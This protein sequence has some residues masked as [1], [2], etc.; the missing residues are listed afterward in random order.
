MRIVVPW[1][2]GA[3]T[4]VGTRALAQVMTGALGQPVVVENRAGANGALGAEAV[5]RAAPDGHT[6]LVGST[7]TQSINAQVF[8]RLAYDPVADFTPITQFARLPGALVVGPGLRQVADLAGFLAAVRAVPGRVTF[9]SWGVASISHLLMERALKTAGNAQMLHA[10]FTG[11]APAITAVAGGQVD[12]MILLAGTAMTAARSGRVRILAVAAER[13]LPQ[14]PE[15]PTFREAGLD[16][17]GGNWF[18][19]FGP[20]RMPEP[21]VRRIAEATMEAVRSPSVTEL[22]HTLSAEIV[23]SPSPEALRDFVAAERERW[24]EVIRA[25]AIQL[26]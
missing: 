7:E 19:L 10:P 14:M 13:R 11:A 12:S 26:E 21:A 24:G 1:P 15:V 23:T 6:L 9:A 22:F 18:A 17:V 25:L 8:R 20:A 4:D 16:V 2:P 5:A 3:F